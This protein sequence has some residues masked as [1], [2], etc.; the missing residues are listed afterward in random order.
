MLFAAT[1]LSGCCPN[2][3][4]AT[5]TV[6][7]AGSGDGGSGWLTIR[8]FPVGAGAYGEL[9]SSG[10]EHGYCDDYIREVRLKL[11]GRTKAIPFDVGS[12]IGACGQQD[13]AVVAWISPAEHAPAPAPGE[14]FGRATFKLATCPLYP[15]DFCGTT[16]GVDVVIDEV[17]P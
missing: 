4:G 5:G 13:W 9:P 14:R 8:Q 1:V 2:G 12:G 6:R 11:D 10:A 17:A 7:G 16:A 15:R 3:P